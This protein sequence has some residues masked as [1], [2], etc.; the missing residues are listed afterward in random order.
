MTSPALVFAKAHQFLQEHLGLNYQKYATSTLWMM[1]ERVLRLGINL[2][3]SVWVARYLGPERFG[4]LHFTLSYVDLFGA[5]ALMGLDQIIV[6][7]LVKQPHQKERI[8]ASAFMV[9]CA[10]ALSAWLLMALT[11]PWLN[12]TPA[13]ELM[14]LWLAGGVVFQVFGVF[15]FHFQATVKAQ[16]IAW[17]QM[18]QTVIGSAVKIY[19]LLIQAE[20]PWFA[21][22]YAMEN[23]LQALLL[24]LFHY[25]VFGQVRLLKGKL[26]LGLELLRDSWPLMLSGVSQMIYL[27]VDQVMLQQ[28][29][30]AEATGHYAAATRISQAWYFFPVIIC[31]VVFPNIVKSRVVESVVLYNKRIINLFSLMIWS[32]ITVS[33]A[34][35]LV[36]VFMIELLYGVAYKESAAILQVH[37]FAGIFVALGIAVNKK[38]VCE[39]KEMN[40]MIRYLIGL[41][42]NVV[43]NVF[44]I[45]KYG[46]WGAALATLF[47]NVAFAYVSLLFIK[48]GRENFMLATKSLVPVH[49]L[50]K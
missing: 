44:L 33:V 19:L 37:I 40:I 42:L 39:A 5:I 26:S 35:S 9:K 28:M 50:R 49:L 15:D 20:L 47:S 23:A 7:E 41:V 13:E 17:V 43:L 30:G 45:Q 24:Y 48:G 16:Y 25:R 14:V 18:S 3:V 1:S 29:V 12:T 31:N 38:D 6:R 2:F 32:G 36:S 27:R 10:G 46:G 22:V 21:M 34:V 8:L 4:S 11:W